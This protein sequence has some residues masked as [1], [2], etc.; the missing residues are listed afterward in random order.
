MVGDV[1]QFIGFYS[2]IVASCSLDVLV[3]GCK[4]HVDSGVVLFFIHL[5]G[6]MFGIEEFVVFLKFCH[7]GVVV[8]VGG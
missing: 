8:D 4:P 7:E 5:L 6:I 2:G 3:Y 1:S